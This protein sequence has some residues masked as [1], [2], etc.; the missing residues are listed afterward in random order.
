MLNII[1]MVF[2][3]LN[4]EIEHNIIILWIILLPTMFLN[5][6]MPPTPIPIPIPSPI[7]IT[8][9][10]ITSIIKHSIQPPFAP[11]DPQLIAIKQI[12]PTNHP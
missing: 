10:P 4:V 5:S 3:L 2:H 11:E 9:N 12:R 6:T 8:S 1:S 7:A